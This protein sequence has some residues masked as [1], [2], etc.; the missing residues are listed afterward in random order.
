M[1][2]YSADCLLI[3][4]NFCKSL[5]GYDKQKSHWLTRKVFLSSQ[6]IKTGHYAYFYPVPKP[7]HTCKTVT[8]IVAACQVVKLESY[9][10]GMQK[11]K[12]PKDLQPEE[13]S[14]EIVSH[15]FQLVRCYKIC[16]I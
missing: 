8:I 4:S 6:L 1:H 2:S 9:D 12:L 10:T 14:V 11:D 16:L 13:V 7:L 15:L 3:F 5:F